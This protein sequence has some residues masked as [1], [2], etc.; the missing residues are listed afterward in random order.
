LAGSQTDLEKRREMCMRG[1]MFVIKS[2]MDEV[3]IEN[4]EKGETANA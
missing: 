3:A 4:K 2:K 1:M